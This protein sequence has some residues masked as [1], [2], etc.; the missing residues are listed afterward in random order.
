MARQRFNTPI[1]QLPLE[2]D[3]MRGALEFHLTQLY[4]PSILRV[5]EIDMVNAI[6]G[7]V[8]NGAY[9][10]TGALYVDETNTVRMVVQ[11]WAMSTE[12]VLRGGAVTAA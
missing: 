11:Q 2:P 3:A 6:R 12:L 1:I 4:N 5:H 10:P 8:E 7:G 9:L